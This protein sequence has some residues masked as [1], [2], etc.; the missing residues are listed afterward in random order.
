MTATASLSA[1]VSI[2]SLSHV[3]VEYG[4][5]LS[6]PEVAASSTRMQFSIPSGSTHNCVLSRGPKNG[7]EG[8]YVSAAW[9]SELAWNPDLGQWTVFTWPMR[10][11]PRR[12]SKPLS[13]CAASDDSI[14][15]TQ[16]AYP[17]GPQTYRFVQREAHVYS[18][19][20]PL[21]RSFWFAFFG[22]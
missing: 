8:V 4:A 13:T 7:P 14:R 15:S 5:D 19:L 17:C 6:G 21:P 20:G 11:N 1:E 22:R 18:P 10:Q 2:L 16:S 3:T 12:S 9:V